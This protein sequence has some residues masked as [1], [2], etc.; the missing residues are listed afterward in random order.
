MIGNI[1]E[2]ANLVLGL[3]EVGEVLLQGLGD[4]LSV[5]PAIRGFLDSDAGILPK[6]DLRVCF[7]QRFVN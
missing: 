1:G 2:G 7:L 5:I 6:G 4:V 3:K